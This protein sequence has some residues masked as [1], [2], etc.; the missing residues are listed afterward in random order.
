MKIAI[1]A[2]IHLATRSDHPE[3][4]NALENILHQSDKDCIEH[5]IIAGDLFDKDYNNPK[6]FEALCKTFPKINLHIIPGNHDVAVSGKSIVGSNIRVYT[7]PTAIEID[8]TS[9][10][11]IPYEEKTKMCDRITIQG[12]GAE[13]GW[14]LIGH[15][16]Y[17]GGVKE[18]NPLEPGT[19][20]P[21]SKST[22]SKFAPRAVFLGHIH[23]PTNISN[24]YYTGSPCGLDISETGTRRF[25]VYDTEDGSITSVPVATDVLYFMESFVI[26]PLENELDIL[27]QEIAK[28]IKSWEI[29]ESEFSK[30]IIRCE[31]MGYT[32]D[33]GAVMT[34]LKDGFKDFRFYNDEGPLIE[35]LSMSS[36]RQLSAIA[37]RTVKLID[38]FEWESND[39]EP[40]KELIK[41]KALDVIYSG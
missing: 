17:Y 10:L 4:Y 11:F 12:D 39:D 24:V 18:Q 13:K 28:R 1:T 29:H 5:L 31:A 22:V 8:Q 36:D 23:K 14:I 20:M 21:L 3:R 16:D 19:Y 2:D 9:F 26:V 41:M 30:I 33:R 37:E 35:R 32:M 38:E 7:T 34:A 6:D 40:D 27:K 15:G 25:L